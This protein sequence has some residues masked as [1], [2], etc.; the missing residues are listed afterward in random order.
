M[1][2]LSPQNASTPL[3]TDNLFNNLETANKFFSAKNQ[4]F[5][6]TEIKDLFALFKQK[7]IKETQLNQLDKMKKMAKVSIVNNQ[8]VS[9][10]ELILTNE[11]NDNEQQIASHIKKILTNNQHKSELR[12]LASRHLQLRDIQK[13]LVEAYSEGKI[14][15]TD[16]QTFNA[17]I[18]A[19]VDRLYSGPV[20]ELYKRDF[21][22]ILEVEDYRVG[23]CLSKRIKS[24]RSHHR[25]T[26]RR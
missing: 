7:N 23:S 19:E 14:D 17:L 5:E 24:I 18:N 11:L 10:F 16:K 22:A 6:L 9:A 2:E 20:R 21:Q 1:P 25:P 26:S 4:F 3:P 12:R 15:E 13:Q 8:D